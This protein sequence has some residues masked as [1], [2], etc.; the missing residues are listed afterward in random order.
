MNSAKRL[1]LI[2]V[3]GLAWPAAADDRPRI[4]L[5][6]SGGAARGIAHVGVL[7]VLEEL[8][9]PVDYVA[10]TSMGAIVGG[11]YASG[12]TA[13][14]I[15]ELLTRLDW[16]DVLSGRT[17]YRDL[18]FR[19]KEDERR[20]LMDIELGINEKGFALPVGLLSGQQLSVQLLKALRPVA[21]VTDFSR[22][23]TPFRAVASDI[24]TGEEVVL[25]GG[26]LAT[27]LR[28]S[29][30][31]PG[32]FSPVELD[33]R[34]L[35]DGGLAN[36]LPV[37]VVRA[38]GADVVIA[39]DVS[40]PLAT[41]EQLAS[42]LG[43]TNQALTVL[44]RQNME[45]RRADADFVLEPDVRDVGT[46]AFE[47]ARGIIDLGQEDARR[48]QTELAAWSLDEDAYRRYQASR[49]VPSPPPVTV[50][51]VEVTGNRWVDERA[52]RRRIRVRPGEP[53][54]FEALED[55]LDWIHGLTDFEQVGY[56]LTERDGTRG[57][58]VDVKE[59]SWGPT[60]LLFG[61]ELASDLEGEGGFT[62]FVN[63]TRSRLNSRGGEW[64]NELRAGED[65]GLATEL[66]QPFDF[67]GRFFVAPRLEVGTEK[68][69]FFDG[70]R[71]IAEYEVSGFEIGLD[72]GLKIGHD[73]EL[74]LGVLRGD[75]EAEVETGPADLPRFDADRAG[76][77]A[78]LRVDS[79]DGPAIPRNGTLLDVDLFLS[80]DS[81]GADLPYDRLQLAAS[82]FLS[83]GRHTWLIALEGGSGLGGDIPFFDEFRVGGLLSLGGYAEGQ[84]RG[85]IYGVGRLGYY[86]KAVETLPVI[87]NGL[88]A[89]AVVESGN[90]WAVN[91]DVDL[92]DL[93]SSVTLFIAA[94]TF[95]GPLFVGYGVAE[96]SN[97]RFYLNLGRTF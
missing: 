86:Y 91:E 5:A 89:G 10:G 16:Q 76:W 12:L 60:Y 20:Y 81:L 54:D 65:Q 95:F 49:R 61:L 19:R 74:R 24:E 45:A 8:R 17:A 64:R 97:D 94:E 69:S 2:L 50:D 30:S 6:L 35:V 7:A 28:A 90:V 93:R 42:F 62:A 9:V 96:G 29:M 47:D 82:Q 58:V 1:L 37:D 73:G 48:R 46:L 26:Q 23:P 41:R 57:L 39:V 11:L 4:G 85:P 92:G 70:E 43:V 52:I 38:M 32:V 14:E 80:R 67:A 68:Q 72:L 75:A 3:L 21:D 79:T 44:T 63:L 51:F 31:I 33:G 87:G 15:D 55:D 22:L 78:R 27:V 36:N 59:K 18:A 88:F 34:L 83:R 25:T 40:E 71:K 66:Y 53:L 13:A 56:R 84:F 77:N